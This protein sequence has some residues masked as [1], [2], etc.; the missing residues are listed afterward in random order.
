MIPF[1]IGDK[2][3]GSWHDGLITGV[4][5]R[6]GEFSYGIEGTA[7]HNHKSLKLVAEATEESVAEA[8]ATVASAEDEGYEEI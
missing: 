4:S 1:R 5:V 2:V 7:W 3:K 6:Q 8:L